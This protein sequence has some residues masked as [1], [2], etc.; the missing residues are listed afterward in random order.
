[1]TDQIDHPTHY[2]KNKE[3]ANEKDQLEIRPA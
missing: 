1:M 3:K 2:T